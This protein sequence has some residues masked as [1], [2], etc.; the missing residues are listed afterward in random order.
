V[1]S[2]GH[3]TSKVLLNF[4]IQQPAHCWL[5]SKFKS[6]KTDVNFNNINTIPTVNNNQLKFSTALCI[7]Q[8]KVDEDDGFSD[9]DL[10]IENKKNNKT[11]FYYRPFSAL[12]VA[13]NK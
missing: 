10:T 9:C 8:L 7:L 11:F 6:Y 2:S 1:L 5:A 12:L 4:C 13:M 3:E